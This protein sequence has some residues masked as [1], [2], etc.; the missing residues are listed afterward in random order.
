MSEYKTYKL[1]FTLDPPIDC[2]EFGDWS[3]DPN[4]ALKGKHGLVTITIE[5][6]AKPSLEWCK[7]LVDTITHEYRIT[8]FY[9][10][11]E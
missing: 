5:C 10:Y 8:D 4:I 3:G 6:D 7:N 9:E 2:P 1:E 11:E